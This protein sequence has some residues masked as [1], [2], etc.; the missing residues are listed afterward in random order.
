MPTA[1]KTNYF[2]P[3][4]RSKTGYIIDGKTYKDED[5]KERVE[6][7][8]VVETK[9]G[10]YTLT[11]S[12]GVKADFNQSAMNETKN[13]IDN[14]KK[15]SKKQLEAL[16]NS[17]KAMIDNQKEELSRQYMKEA[18]NEYLKSMESKK[19]MDQL[20][21]ARG[22]N[23]GMSESRILQ[24]QLAYEN[25]VN[26]LK[27]RRDEG[28]SELDAKLLALRNETDYNI[29]A[30]NSEYDKLYLEYADKNIDRILAEMRNEQQI[31]SQNYNNL[32]NYERGI[33]E[34]D[35]DYGQR[36]EEFNRY[37]FESDRD[38]DR[39]VL[40]FDEEM[41][42]RKTEEANDVAQFEA[43]LA[44]DREKFNHQVNNDNRNYNLNVQKANKSS[45]KSNSDTAYKRA[46]EEAE[47]KADFGDYSGYAKIFDWDDS[48]VEK[49]E[50]EYN[51]KLHK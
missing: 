40:E 49:A 3:M 42:Q 51:I 9:D 4:G 35:R 7:G 31:N 20:L 43:S 45:S 34:S 22:M 15:N 14:M 1:Y 29:A 26:S 33:F 32:L 6:K 5:G 21:K 28:I 44:L 17:K 2:D 10:Y 47:I 19:N 8:S 30:Q 23:G 25:A 36:L 50:K 24:N 39:K 12:G 48:T 16:Y 13:N 37:I 38:Y 41:A 27:E 18:K 46:L 11:S